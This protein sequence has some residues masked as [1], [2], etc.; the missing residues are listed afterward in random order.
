MHPSKS[1]VDLEIRKEDRARWS[2]EITIHRRGKPSGL[3]VGVAA[4]VAAAALLDRA[5]V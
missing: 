1:R 5:K 4:R 3:I 2:G